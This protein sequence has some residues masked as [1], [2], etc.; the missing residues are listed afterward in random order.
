MH[1]DPWQQSIATLSETFQEVKISHVYREFNAKA[2]MVSKDALKLDEGVLTV[3]HFDQ[4]EL[5]QEETL[6]IY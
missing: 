3:Q 4:K 1:L 2:D 6:V 5:I